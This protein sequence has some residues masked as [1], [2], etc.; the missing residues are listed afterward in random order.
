VYSILAIG[1]FL[2]TQDNKQS[3]RIEV[4]GS[5]V[6]EVELPKKWEAKV[7]QTRPQ[8]PPTL[9]VY[10]PDHSTLSLQMTFIP[11]KPGKILASDDLKDLVRRGNAQYVDGS[12]ERKLELVSLDSKTGEGYYCSFTDASLVDVKPVPEGKYLKVSSGVFVINRTMVTFTV[13]FN[14]AGADD[15]KAALEAVAKT[16]KQD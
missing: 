12:V 1:A 5:E 11:I 8:I 13:L 3:I 15:Q 4:P 9:R 7:I 2:I 16:K 6:Y 14:P 10:A